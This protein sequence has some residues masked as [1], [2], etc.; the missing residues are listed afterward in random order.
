MTVECTII[1]G[2]P[3]MRCSD[4]KLARIALSK[5]YRNQQ[6][7]SCGNKA[8][9]N[10][11]ETASEPESPPQ[12]N[13]V[14]DWDDVLDFQEESEGFVRGS[15]GIAEMTSESQA[16]ALLS[17]DCLEPQEVLEVVKAAHL[18]PM[19]IRRKSKVVGEPGVVNLWVFG[20]YVKGGI[21]GITRVSKD[22]PMLT[23]LLTKYMRQH[24]KGPFA[25]LVVAENV[26]F[27]PHKDPNEGTYASTIVGLSSFSGGH[28]W[29]ECS[30]CD[31]EEDKAVWRYVNPHREPIPGQLNRLDG[32]RS[33]K[34]CGT[35]WHGTEPH[36]GTRS[37][38]VCYMPRNW[39]SLGSGIVQH[40][41]LWGSYFQRIA[42]EA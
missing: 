19:T 36:V 24:A 37:V 40:L 39:Q 41:S 32:G 31:L 17:E 22:H 1:N 3:Y 16:E 10:P 29:T 20:A 23:R 12:E 15:Q 18:K 9:L 42:L 2:F 27:K 5:H 34:F 7:G 38:C 35:R 30:P 11:T 28:L 26:A 13:Q 14:V 8:V 33:A 21:H 6:K 4:F 25:S